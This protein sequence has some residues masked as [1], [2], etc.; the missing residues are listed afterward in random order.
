[1]IIMQSYEKLTEKI[2]KGR[3]LL[4]IDVRSPSEYR[5]ARIPG[6][7][8]I[9]VFSDKERKKNGNKGSGRNCREKNT[10]YIY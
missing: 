5:E 1:M 8:N 2:K 6:A 10:G 7:I 9:P 3:K 4:F